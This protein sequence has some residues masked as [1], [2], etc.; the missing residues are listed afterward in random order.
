MRLE[1]DVTCAQL[2][3]LVT[4]YFEGTLSPALVER[5]EQHLVICDGCSIHVQQMRETIR[6]T[7]SLTEADLD[8]DLADQ[9]LTAFRNWNAVA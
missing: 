4:E 2:V 9:L 6:L 5:F 7:G 1:D 8:Q 3:E